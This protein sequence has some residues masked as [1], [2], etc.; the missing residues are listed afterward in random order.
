MGRAQA[1]GGDIRD[2]DDIRD[3]S[4]LGCR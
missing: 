2:K 3:T 1:A 4:A